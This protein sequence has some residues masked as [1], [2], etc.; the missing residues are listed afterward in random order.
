VNIAADTMRRFWS[1]LAH[2]HAQLWNASEIGRSFGVADTT[3]RNGA[4]TMCESFQLDVWTLLQIVLL[5]AG[6][7]CTR[8]RGP[9]PTR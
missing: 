2:H 4:A 6:D 8:R 5:Q 1:M 3:V 7:L 9:C